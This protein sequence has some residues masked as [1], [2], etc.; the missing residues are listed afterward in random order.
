MDAESVLPDIP[1]LAIEPWKSAW[2]QVYSLARVIDRHRFQK[3]WELRNFEYEHFYN[4][5]V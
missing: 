3:E 2:R 1:H 5:W 4:A